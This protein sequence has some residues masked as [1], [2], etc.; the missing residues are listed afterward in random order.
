MDSGLRLSEK[1]EKADLSRIL[2]ELSR[3]ANPKKLNYPETH[4]KERSKK[5]DLSRILTELSRPHRPEKVELSRNP[6]K[7]KGRKS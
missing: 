5:V 6:Y 1:I 2:D 7:A 3:P 4:I